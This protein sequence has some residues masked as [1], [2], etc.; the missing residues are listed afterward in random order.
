MNSAHIYYKN[1]K[2][3]GDGNAS[4]NNS[5]QNR[6]PLKKM[7]FII[8][9]QARLSSSR[10]PNKVLMEIKG[11]PLLQFLVERLNTVFD[12]S[13]LLVA[14]S[15]RIEDDKIESFCNELNIQC[16]RGSF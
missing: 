16:Y 6:F 1:K 4:K 15:T 5:R 8:I 3:F 12:K 9:I 11:T 13:K 10:L 7:D 14:T 2:I